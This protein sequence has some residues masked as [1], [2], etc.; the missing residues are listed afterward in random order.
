M[1]FLLKCGDWEL[2]GDILTTIE[3]V[4]YFAPNGDITLPTR[5]QNDFQHLLE[6]LNTFRDSFGEIDKLKIT[7]GDEE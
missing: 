1:K 7:Q 6:I 2:K 5:L 4:Y 3:G